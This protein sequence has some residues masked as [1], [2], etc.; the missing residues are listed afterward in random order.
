MFDHPLK[1]G[2]EKQIGR[3]NPSK[4][5]HYSRKHQKA[6]VVVK[7]AR[8]Y[9]AIDVGLDVERLDTHKAK[10]PGRCHSKIGKTDLQSQPLKS[11]QSETGQR[12]KHTLTKMLNS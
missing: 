2:R 1:R 9:T 4:R 12:D 10:K 11:D 3:H 7:I 6:S 5:H 8:S